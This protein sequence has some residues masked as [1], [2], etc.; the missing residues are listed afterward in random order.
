MVAAFVVFG[1]ITVRRA[2]FPKRIYV[3]RLQHDSPMDMGTKAD[4][5]AKYHSSE[6]MGF[7]KL[8]W[9]TIALDLDPYVKPFHVRAYPPFFGI[10][11]F[12]FTALWQ[13]RGAG[14]ALF[15]LVSFEFALISAWCCSRLFRRGDRGGRF[16]L[17]ALFFLL[18]LPLALNVMARCESDMLVLAPV[19]VAFLWLAQG[20]K[21]FQAGALLG[22]AAAFKIL[23]GLFGVYLLCT[24]R[25]RALLGMIAGGLF[26]TV[27]LPLVVWGPQRAWDLHVSWYRHVVAPYHSEG[28]EA[29]IGKTA[30]R[31]SNQSMSAALNRYLRPVGVK[32]R[33]GGEPLSMNVAWLTERQVRWVVKVLHAC[34]GLGIILVWI[35]CTPKGERPLSRVVLFAT[36]GPAILLLSEIS[37]TT[38]HVLLVPALAAI[39]VRAT[40][41]DGDDHAQRWAWTVIVYLLALAGVAIPHV[42]IFTPMLPATL[43]LL[44]ACVVLAIGDRRRTASEALAAET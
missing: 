19:C 14:S 38:H 26:C 44:V 24:R 31:S 25:W 29:V 28:A 15:Y 33:R 6:F 22:F 36:V 32:T 30:E 39:I 27:V 9:G 4:K 10:A 5:Q 2:E 42:K 1:V 16:G 37:L 12:P 17:F 8:S 35:L 18:L 7:R 40:A 34:I 13:I 41:A 3:P 23:P 43:A 21:S 20:R 11:F